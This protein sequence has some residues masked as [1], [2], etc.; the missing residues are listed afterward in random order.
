MRQKRWWLISGG[1]KERKKKTVNEP[2]NI[3]GE[4]V[5]QLILGCSFEYGCHVDEGM[6][7]FYFLSKPQILQRVKQ[8]VGDLLPVYGSVSLLLLLLSA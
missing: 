5:K 4:E 3:I 2:I 7:R 8:D 6:R 1:K